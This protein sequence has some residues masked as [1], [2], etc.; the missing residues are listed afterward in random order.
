MSS[1]EFHTI[2]YY[3]RALAN[4]NNNIDFSN[5][6]WGFSLGEFTNDLAE[7]VEYNLPSGSA[8]FKMGQINVVPSGNSNDI[9]GNFNMVVH[10][11]ASSNGT[12][13][14]Y[15][16]LE[17]D[18]ITITIDENT[19]FVQKLY[20]D[21]QTPPTGN[22]DILSLAT[23]IDDIATFKAENLTAM[24]NEFTGSLIQSWRGTINSINIDSSNIIAQM[25][26]YNN[27]TDSNVFNNGDTI[28][29]SE[30]AIYNLE[31]NDY[32]GNKQVIIEPTE[33]YILITHDDNA[34][35]LI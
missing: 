32:N 14:S 1:P 9:K 7:F 34:P 6:N 11:D 13:T 30:P 26:N 23:N 29:I 24:A 27:S 16:T 12:M 2:Q 19:N 21:Y 10:L 20:W 35:N 25:A 28:H 18:Q 3:I 8:S 5:N 22:E 33:I 31:I 15:V 17:G 4:L